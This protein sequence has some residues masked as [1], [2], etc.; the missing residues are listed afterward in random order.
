[1]TC[2]CNKNSEGVGK[3]NSYCGGN[4]NKPCQEDNDCKNKNKNSF[5][6]NEF[7]KITKQKYL[8]N[9]TQK[10]GASNTSDVSNWSNLKLENSH[11][12]AK[13]VYDD[14]KHLYGKPNIL[15]NVKGGIAIWTQKELKNKGDNLHYEIILRDEAV[16]H[17]VP[18]KHYDF[19]TSYIKVFIPQEKFESVLSVSGSVTYDGLKKL[20]SA[21]CGSLEANY[22]TFRTCLQRLNNKEENYK[23]NIMNKNNN[24]DKNKKFI[25]DSVKSNHLKYNKELKL[26]YY[27][28]AFPNGC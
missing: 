2:K 18:A 27:E 14:L 25:M 4:K 11:P 21:R 26:P 10:G 16:E 5:T 7:K 17:C 12:S 3:C 13:Q 19:L 6:I 15:I 23:E 24:S 8:I 22:A 28:L 1:M 9:Y 20:L